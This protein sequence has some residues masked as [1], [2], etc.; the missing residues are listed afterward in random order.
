MVIPAVVCMENMTHMPSRTPLLLMQ[1]L[2]RD[3]MSVMLVFPVSTSIV[4]YPDMVRGIGRH[5]K[6]PLRKGPDLMSFMYGQGFIIMG[7]KEWLTR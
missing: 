7:R 6:S 2:T 5:R 3:V 4:S 1:S